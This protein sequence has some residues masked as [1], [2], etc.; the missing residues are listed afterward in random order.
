MRE[1]TSK[2]INESLE[3]K[4]V[5]DNIVD[6][7]DNKVVSTDYVPP[8]PPH[9]G[10]MTING[11]VHFLNR[12]DRREAKKMMLKRMKEDERKR[13]ALEQKGILENDKSD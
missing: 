2:E 4:S 7:S 10:L 5:I 6:G 3:N 1:L 8:L 12:K 9:K 11:E 13:S